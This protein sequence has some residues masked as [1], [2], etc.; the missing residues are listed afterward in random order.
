MPATRLDNSSVDADS[1]PV[2]RARSWLDAHRRLCPHRAGAVLRAAR[3]AVSLLPILMR[4]F[5]AIRNLI[6]SAV[7]SLLL[8]TLLF[9]AVFDRPLSLCYLQQQIDIKLQR[10]ASI[11]RPKLVILAGSN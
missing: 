6:T 8:Y 1:A 9:G 2:V 3:D 11:D 10:A 7:A 5:S 4:T